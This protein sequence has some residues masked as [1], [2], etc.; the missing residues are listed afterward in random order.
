MQRKTVFQAQKVTWT[1]KKRALGSGLIKL[2]KTAGISYSIE[3]KAISQV[4]LDQYNFL[5]NFHLPLPPD[6]TFCISEK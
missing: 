1:F 3:Q 6:P 5:V 4:K 2:F